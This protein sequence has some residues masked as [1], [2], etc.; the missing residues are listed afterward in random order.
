MSTAVLALE[1]HMAAKAAASTE[2]ILSNFKRDWESTKHLEF[3]RDVKQA[4]VLTDYMPHF[5]RKTGGKDHLLPFR[6][7]RAIVGISAQHIGRLLKFG[8]FVEFCNLTGYKIRI[9]EW[10]F[11]AYWKACSDPIA[12]RLIQ[13]EVHEKARLAYE[14]KIFPMIIERVQEGKPA[15]PRNQGVKSSGTGRPVKVTRTL[16]QLKRKEV[17]EIFDE[18]M[19]DIQHMIELAG[20]TQNTFSPSILASYAKHLKGA[21]IKLEKALKG[22]IID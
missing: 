1:E 13:G 7:L 12:L 18:I 6:Q 22:N 3:E 8:R 16:V 20:A 10:A 2:E 5:K 9:A 15:N 21:G 11:R 17:H 19:D 14:Q 4:Q